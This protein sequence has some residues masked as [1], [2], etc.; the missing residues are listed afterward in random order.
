MSNGAIGG[1]FVTKDNTEGAIHQGTLLVAQARN[2]LTP[3][4]DP[5]K[6]FRSGI[7]VDA[8]ASYFG[9]EKVDLDLL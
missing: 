4:T 2:K 7:N 5:E 1:F 3:D 8:T 9:R 6:E